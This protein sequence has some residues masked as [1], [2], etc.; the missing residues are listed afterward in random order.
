MAQD[1]ALEG[2]GR[3]SRAA[4][5]EAALQGGSIGASG[6]RGGCLV[7]GGLDLPGLLVLAAREGHYL[8][9]VVHGCLLLL[10]GGSGRGWMRGAGP[11]LIFAGPSSK[12]LLVALHSGGVLAMW[13]VRG[14][15]EVRVDLGLLRGSG[16]SG[17]SLGVLTG[18]RRRHLRALLSFL[19]TS[20]GIS[21]PVLPD[22][23]LRVKALILL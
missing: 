16:C 18:Q 12:G 17:E 11:D 4:M 7:Q 1:P 23:V 9:L 3:H 10:Q 14:P 20:L 19:E 8:L 22:Q 13:G 21:D 6:A 5:G 15:M 2:V